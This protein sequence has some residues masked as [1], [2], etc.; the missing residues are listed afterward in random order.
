MIIPVLNQTMT[1]LWCHT[2]F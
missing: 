2:P 1:I